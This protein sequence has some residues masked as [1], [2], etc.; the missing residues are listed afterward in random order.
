MLNK[1]IQSFE[2][3][4]LLTTVNWLVLEVEVEQVVGNRSFA[5]LLGDSKIKDPAVQRKDIST[6][7]LCPVYFKFYFR[8]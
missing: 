3:H 8:L 5:S 7:R 2:R 4:E 1:A 6:S